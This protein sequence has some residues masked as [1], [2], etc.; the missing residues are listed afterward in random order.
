MKNKN[1]IDNYDSEKDDISRI[2]SLPPPKF[3][4]GFS[5]LTR[6]K[7][8]VFEKAFTVASRGAI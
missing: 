6:K 1:T 8:Q 7:I 3:T 2:S 5:T 4:A